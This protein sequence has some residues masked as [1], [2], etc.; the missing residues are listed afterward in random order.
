MNGLNTWIP[1]TDI[2]LRDKCII[3]T[4]DP[5]GIVSRSWSSATT[6]TPG[7]RYRFGSKEIA[8]T[9]SNATSTGS[10][11]YLDFGARLYNPRTAIW[12]SQDPMAEKYYPFSPYLYCAGNPVNVVDPTG[13]DIAVLVIDGQHIALLI[14]NEE[15]K[16]EY[17]SINGNN[18]YLSGNHTGGRQ[19][20][21]LGENLFDRPQAFL[22]SY[23]N[24]DKGKE[25]KNDKS[26]ANYNYSSAFIIETDDDHLQDNTIRTEFKRISKE[27]PY[28]LFKPNHC[29]TVVQRS[30]Q[31]GGI[32]TRAPYSITSP[33][34]VVSQGFM[35]P[36]LPSS[37]YKQIKWNNSGH[38][39]HSSK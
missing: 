28:S 9:V 15:G 10:D 39:I 1:S 31:K 24:Q 37:A 34:G 7:K 17:Y 35:F 33:I 21:D 11:K 16:W 29:A 5:N 27:E 14:E 19:F 6:D 3:L 8:G 25:R 30:L 26:I 2:K 12:L 18:M 23:Y 22:D 38:E 13:K 32:E 4:Y 20:D 36:Y